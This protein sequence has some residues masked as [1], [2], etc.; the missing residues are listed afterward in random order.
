VAGARVSKKG[1]VATKRHCMRYLTGEVN[2]QKTA[3]MRSKMLLHKSAVHLM[4]AGKTIVWDRVP[5][6]ENGTRPSLPDYMVTRLVKDCT[7]PAPET[8][9]VLKNV[10]EGGA[11]RTS[12]ENV[13]GPPKTLRKRSGAPEKVEAT[14]GGPPRTLNKTFRNVQGPPQ[15]LGKRF[16]LRER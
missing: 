13:R 7:I 3:R 16:A 4:L 5:C 9:P 12:L 15:P 8:K 14:F 2:S 1:F 10:L 6:W 11:S